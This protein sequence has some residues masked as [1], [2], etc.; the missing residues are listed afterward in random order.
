MTAQLIRIRLF[1]FLVAVGCATSTR[2]QS[3]PYSLTIETPK[4]AAIAGTDIFINITQTNTSESPV[5]CGS[6][7]RGSTDLSLLYDVRKEDGTR[8]KERPGA[9]DAADDF[10]SCD[11]DPGRSLSRRYLLS[12]LFDLS[13]PGTFLVQVVR[14]ID[15]DHVVKSNVISLVV[16]SAEEVDKQGTSRD[17]K[18]GPLASGGQPGS[19]HFDNTGLWCC[20]NGYFRLDGHSP[21]TKRSASESLDDYTP[22]R[23]SAKP[24]TWPSVQF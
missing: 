7:S 2:G 3:A 10:K 5:S 13:T 19:Y 6:M 12:W 15:P 18:I 4:K 14:H 1:L 16:G 22:K 17:A 23:T 8:L 21:E 11:L 20:S 9:Y 24:S